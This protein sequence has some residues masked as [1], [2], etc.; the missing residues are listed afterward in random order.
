MYLFGV[1]INQGIQNIY[2]ATFEFDGILIMI[3]IL[4]IKDNSVI[5]NEVK[6]STQIPNPDIN[7]ESIKINS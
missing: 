1:V 3:D 4:N 5:I 7:I 6:S 2:E